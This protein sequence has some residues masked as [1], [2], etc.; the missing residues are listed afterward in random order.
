MEEPQLK[1]HLSLVLLGEERQQDAP[2]ANLTCCF[3]HFAAAAVA[4]ASLSEE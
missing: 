1:P 3:S 2:L 4:A